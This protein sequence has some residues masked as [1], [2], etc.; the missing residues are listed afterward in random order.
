MTSNSANR[1][2]SDFVREL[3]RNIGL[4]ML[5]SAVCAVAIN[6]IL[7]PHRFVSGGVTGLA[8]VIHYIVP[9]LPVSGLYFVLN[10]PLFAMGWKFVGRRFFLYSIAGMIVFSASLK[11][12]HVPVNI[13]DPVPSALLAGI[14][15]GLGSGIILRSVGSAGGTDILAVTLLNRFSIRL[16]T[17]TLAFNAGVLI[18]AALSSALEPVLYTLIY[19][20][21]T[22]YVL[23]LM[24]TG[25]SQRKAVLIISSQ[26]EEIAQRVLAQVRR[27]VTILQGQGAFSGQGQQILYTVITFR[28]LAKAKGIIRQVDPGAFVVVTDT[29]EVMGHRIGNQPHW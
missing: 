12:V 23:D 21:V 4:I 1:S 29:L 24:V 17:T 10:L 9:S 2:T 18:L 25:L 19:M 5:G 7:V 27:G 15:S 14:I 3:S 22:S 6:G 26:W 11:W 28:E 20:F 13:H 16:G 8:L